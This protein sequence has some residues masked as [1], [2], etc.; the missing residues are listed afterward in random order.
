MYVPYIDMDRTSL[1]NCSPMNMQR[2]S[3]T[4]LWAYNQP[5]QMLLLNCQLVSTSR[6]KTWN[7]VFVNN[8]SFFLEQ[9]DGQSSFFLKK[10]YYLLKTFIHYHVPEINWNGQVPVG[11]VFISLAKFQIESLSLNFFSLFTRTTDLISTNG[12]KCLKLGSFCLEINRDDQILIQLN[13]PEILEDGEQLWLHQH[14]YTF[15]L[16]MEQFKAFNKVMLSG[17]LW[18]TPLPDC[19]FKY[20]GDKAYHCVEKLS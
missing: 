14:I 16:K 1:Q 7:V 13:F 15:H 9:N 8:L 6:S 20:P 4:H 11:R 18:K 2:C 10:N 19:Q 5:L 3:W 12:F 17:G